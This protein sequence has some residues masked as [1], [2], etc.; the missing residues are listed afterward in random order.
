VLV[1]GELLVTAGVLV[2]LLLV[3]LLWWTD[4]TAG[5]AAQEEISQ[6]QR[7]WSTTAPPA[8]SVSS[9]EVVPEALI[10][11][12]QPRSGE[13]FAVLHI[14]RLGADWAEPILQGTA[15]SM[16]RSGVGHYPGTAMPGMTGNLAVAGHRTTYGHPFGEIQR[17]R[18]GDPVVVE[19]R[20]GWF[21]YRVT[22]HAVVSPGQRSVVAAVPG[23]P[24]ARAERAML[25]LTTCHPKYSARERWV[26]HAELVGSRARTAGPPPGMGL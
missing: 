24:G 13:A 15:S 2:V 19:T 21:V 8:A 7:Q 3:W 17:V 16:L 6:L 5:A 18:D 23:R 1:V 11:V 20:N 9:T 4:R 12:R 26:V 10:D 25:T 14:P 22:S